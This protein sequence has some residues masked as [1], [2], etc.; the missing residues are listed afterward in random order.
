MYPTPIIKLSVGGSV[1][2]EDVWTNGLTLTP[3][4][5]LGSAEDAFL[6]LTPQQFTTAVNAFYATGPSSMDSYNTVEWIKL[7]LIGRDGKYLRDAKIYDYP[8][9]RPG[10]GSFNVSPHDTMVV[11]L[12][13]GTKRG[14]ARRGRIYLPS[15]FASVSA[16]T[17]RVLPADVTALVGKAKTYLEAV[18]AIGAAAIPGGVSICIASDV[19]EGQIRRVTALEVG[20]LMDNQS[21]RRNR[22]DEVY[23]ESPI[24]WFPTP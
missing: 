14:L 8:T 22:L 5:Q 3:N 13:T 23:V 20:N 4:N 12:L 19:R 18:D 10:T 6:A 21:R 16:T 2:G 9:P 15:G 11:S 17:G 7:A 24:V 1:A